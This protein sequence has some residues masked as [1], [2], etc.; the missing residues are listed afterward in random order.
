[1]ERGKFIVIYGPNNLGKTTQAKLLTFN[2]AVAGQKARYLKY[3]VYEIPT[4][5][6]IDAVLRRGLGLTDR[7]L[8]KEFVANRSCFEPDLREM[9]ENGEIVVAEDYKGTGIAWGMV[10]GISLE[11]MEEINSGLLDEDLAICLD[12]ERFSSGIE[13]G[14]R[15]E[16]QRDWQEARRAH[17]ELAE[18]YG[19]Q[20]VDANQ[21]EGKVASDI[22]DIVMAKINF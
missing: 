7:Q 15:Y 2:L 21:S 16:E 10:N 13:R 6:R 11:E 17:Q 12:G 18:R 3:P 9:L 8:Q 4:G 5:Q 1:M 20:V 14:H 22:W 19:W